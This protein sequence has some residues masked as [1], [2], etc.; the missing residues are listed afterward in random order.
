MNIDLHMLPYDTGRRGWRMGA[1]PE[2]FINSGLESFLSSRGHFLRTCTIEAENESSGEIGT[3]FDLYGRL[4]QAVSASA[5]T[6]AFPV[7]LSGNC[8]AA[9]GTLSGLETDPVGIIWLDAHGDFNTPETTT[10]GFLDGMGLAAAAGLCWTKLVAKIPHFR[11]VQGRHILHLGGS[12]IESDELALMRSRE[13]MLLSLEDLRQSNFH[14]LLPALD[15][16]RSELSDVYVHLDL[17]VLDPVKTRANHFPSTMGLDADQVKGILRQI[18]ERLNIRAVGVASY[19]P[20]YDPRGSTLR[21]GMQLIAA[22]LG[23]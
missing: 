8:G 1:G 9:L 17:D 10:S 11:P 22:A 23:S 19:D 16:L 2:H 12:D 3:A 5:G 7:V 21:A 4:A 6:G 15:R 20:A 14:A 13:V 18:R